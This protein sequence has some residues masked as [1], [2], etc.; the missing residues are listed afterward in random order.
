MEKI[1]VLK[2]ISGKMFFFGRASVF[3][4]EFVTPNEFLWFWWKIIVPIPALESSSKNNVHFRRGSP[5][6]RTWHENGFGAEIPSRAFSQGTSEIYI[7]CNPHALRGA[8][9]KMKAAGHRQ[10]KLIFATPPG[11]ERD[12]KKSYIF[13]WFFC[14]FRNYENFDAF[15]AHLKHSE[16]LT[17]WNCKIGARQTLRSLLFREHRRLPLGRCSKTKK[18][19]LPRITALIVFCA[20]LRRRGCQKLHLMT[21]PAWESWFPLHDFFKTA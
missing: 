1:T 16:R 9:K 2:S 13:K 6:K 7:N 21:P 12:C 4:L 20:P 18:N 3:M 10:R 8:Q 19:A 17:F 11:R 14:G 5:E 15:F